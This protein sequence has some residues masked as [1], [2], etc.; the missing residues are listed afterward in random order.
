MLNTST[1]KKLKIFHV[2]K[3]TW[4]SDTTI[5]V[6]R[7]SALPVERI[8]GSSQAGVFAGQP[9]SVGCSSEHPVETRY[10]AEPSSSS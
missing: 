4:C 8:A 6:I 5:I 1:V 9:R 3:D 2:D 7:A 10:I